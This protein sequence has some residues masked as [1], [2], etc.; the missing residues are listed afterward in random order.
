MPP[1]VLRCAASCVR[2]GCS[3]SS[4]VLK[5]T[6][7]H[8][9]SKLR[10]VE[11]V[12]VCGRCG[13]PWSVENVMNLPAGTS[14][15]RGA[16]ARSPWPYMRVKRSVSGAGNPEARIFNVDVAELLR[17][18]AVAQ[19]MLRS[20]RLYWPAHVY[21]L[22]VLRFTNVR[23]RGGT[24]ALAGYLAHQSTGRHRAGAW[25][26][27]PFTWNRDR[28]AQLVHEGR[29]AWVERLIVA[30]LLKTS[31]THQTTV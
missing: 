2:A 11:P 23:G 16:S 6:T 21:F 8:A 10:L 29:G 19:R 17:L 1:T 9:K 5:T 20:R 24:R 31:I 14:S 28:V 13:Y 7:G 25:P 12:A 27:A 30:S 15:T 18:R 3:S 22:Y 4:W 26:R